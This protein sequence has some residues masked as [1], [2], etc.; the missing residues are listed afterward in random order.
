MRFFVL[1]ATFFIP[2]IGL[3][4][5]PVG[6]SSSGGLRQPNM[7]T[8]AQFLYRNSNYSQDEA[9]TTRN[10]FDLKELELQ[11]YADVDPYSRLDAIV[12]IHPKFTAGTPPTKSWEVEA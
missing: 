7:S 5:S 9:S 8:N 3:A 2:F 4:E 11:F 10:G 12:S 6:S 1:A